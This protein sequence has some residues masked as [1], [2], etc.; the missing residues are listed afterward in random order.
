MTPGPPRTTVTRVTATRVTTPSFC[1]LC[2]AFCGILVTVEGD[3]VVEVGGDADNPVSRGYTCSKGRASGDLHHHP[4]RLDAPLLGRGDARTTVDWTRA[5]DHVADEL[6][7]IIAE[8]GPNA[9]AAYRASGW[10]FDF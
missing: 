6:G 5:L 9:V 8:S 3:R 10:G 4:E 7:R 1:R 2:P